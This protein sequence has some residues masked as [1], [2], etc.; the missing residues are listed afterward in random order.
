M[1]C[2]A[3][4]GTSFGC[5]STPIRTEQKPLYR[6]APFSG[7]KTHH[8]RDSKFKELSSRYTSNLS[9]LEYGANSN[10]CNS[11]GDAE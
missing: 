6:Y 7:F 10:D 4:S 3:L 5:C 11:D 9:P 2:L 8:T 1:L